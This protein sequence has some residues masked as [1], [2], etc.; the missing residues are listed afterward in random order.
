[1]I[2]LLTYKN[3]ASDLIWIDDRA[4]NSFVHR[5]GTKL[6][7]SIDIL[8]ALHSSGKLSDDLFGGGVSGIFGSV[9][10]RISASS[11]TLITR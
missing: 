6:V 10:I 7:D 2:D 3:D 4:M 11:Y 1:M 5:D 9:S 8:N